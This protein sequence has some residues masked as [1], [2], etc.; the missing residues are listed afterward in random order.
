MRLYQDQDKWNAKIA[1][2][3]TPLRK[4]ELDKLDAT[5]EGMGFKY[6]KGGRDANGTFVEVS[7]RPGLTVEQITDFCDREG[8]AAVSIQPDD[9]DRIL[10]QNLAAFA[11]KRRLEIDGTDSVSILAPDEIY[12]TL[13][14]ELWKGIANNGEKPTAEE[15][16]YI[17]KDLIAHGFLD[18]KDVAANDEWEAKESGPNLQLEQEQGEWALNEEYAKEWQ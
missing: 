8:F 1:A 12:S 13:D 15:T 11:L 7:V 6:L 17:E 3:P 18:P 2:I 10:G 4:R 14:K 16:A 9:C 5:Y